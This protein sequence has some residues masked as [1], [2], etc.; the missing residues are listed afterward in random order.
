MMMF[1]DEYISGRPLTISQVPCLL[2]C[3]L[4]LSSVNI[5]TVARGGL[6]F[7][8]AIRFLLAIVPLTT[9]ASRSLLPAAMIRPLGLVLLRSVPASSRIWVRDTRRPKEFAIMAKQAGP[10]PELSKC[11]ISFVT[12]SFQKNESDNHNNKHMIIPSNDHIF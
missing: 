1:H 7:A 4:L 10:Q 11:L 9:L 12:P 2:L 8:A 6:N 5:R 3:P